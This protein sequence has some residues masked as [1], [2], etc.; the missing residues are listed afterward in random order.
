MRR[1]GPAPREAHASSLR[2]APESDPRIEVGIEEV[3]EG[4]EEDNEEGSEEGDRHERR[5]VEVFG[6]F[7]RIE[8]YAVEAEELFGD[9]R[10]AADQQAEVEAEQCHYR[11]Q[12]VAQHVTRH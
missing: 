1:A 12:R 5:Q 4:V 7:S 8:P 9:D 6:C 3:D 2:G 11:D 10:R